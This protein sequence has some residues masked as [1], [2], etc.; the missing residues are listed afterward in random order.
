M[1]INDAP[2]SQRNI[3]TRSQIMV[4]SSSSSLPRTCFTFS[5]Q[6]CPAF[7][8][9]CSRVSP[10]FL[11]HIP[12]T[13]ANCERV[14]GAERRRAGRGGGWQRARRNEVGLGSGCGH[15]WKCLQSTLVFKGKKKHFQRKRNFFQRKPACAADDARALGCE[16]ARVSGTRRCAC[17]CMRV[18]LRE[19]F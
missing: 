1:E 3:L 11:S 2:Q 17:V 19:R 15:E 16:G 4:S 12:R 14:R 13:C 10:Y 7:A 6:T 8:V 9:L 5:Q 18:R